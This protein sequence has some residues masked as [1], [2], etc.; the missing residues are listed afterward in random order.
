MFIIKSI[1]DSPAALPI[2]I[3]G[4]SPIKVAVPPTFDEKI[5]IKRYGTGFTSSI[6]A[7]AIVIGPTRRTVVTLSRQE[8][9]T[10]VI[11]TKII[12]I[13]Q[14]SAFT[15]LAALIAM[16]SNIPD[17]FS[18]AMNSIMPTSTPIVSKSTYLIASSKLSTLV[19]KITAAPISA[20]SV[21]SIFPVVI[22]TITP[23]KTSIDIISI[24]PPPDKAIIYLFYQNAIN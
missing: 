12:M 6:L 8:D 9:K 14:G 11:I 19:S 10:A 24:I 13:F 2:I 5:S 20:D 21:L 16:Y 15:F 3:F 1:K 17:C 4:G 23:R 18:T 7:I 22:K